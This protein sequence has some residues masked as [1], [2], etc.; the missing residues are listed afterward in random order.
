LKELD[1][2]CKMKSMVF[3]LT[4]TKEKKNLDACM[5]SQQTLVNYVKFDGDFDLISIFWY[6]WEKNM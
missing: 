5:V 2:T 3:R 4:L 1:K 6:S